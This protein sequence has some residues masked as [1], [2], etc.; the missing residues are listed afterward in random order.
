MEPELRQAACLG[1]VEFLKRALATK[2]IDYFL[3]YYSFTDPDGFSQNEMMG[4]ILHLSARKDKLNFMR[5]AMKLLPNH[6]VLRLLS[7]QDEC[8][9]NPLHVAAAQKACFEPV[10][11][12]LGFYNSL[13]EDDNNH[14]KGIEKPWLAL[15]EHNRTPLHVVLSGVK[16]TEDD[17]ECAL[18]ILSI[19]SLESFCNT[20]DSQGNSPLFYAV[21]NRFSR[22]SEKILKSSSSYSVSGEYGFTPLHFASNSS[23]LFLSHSI[24]ID[25]E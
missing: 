12:I 18:E 3:S 13:S 7:Q 20:V 22:V 8:D 17:E 10:G 23:G 21:K 14:H 19:E 6:V 9:Q 5:E 1:D 16:K 4:N 11:L 15:N 2:S 24:L 25:F